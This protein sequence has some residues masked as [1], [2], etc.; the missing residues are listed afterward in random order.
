MLGNNRNYIVKRKKNI[1]NLFKKMKMT[2][3][4]PKR[5]HLDKNIIPPF[6]T[7]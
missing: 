1:S 5:L 7:V 4:D 3:I 2:S 6:R